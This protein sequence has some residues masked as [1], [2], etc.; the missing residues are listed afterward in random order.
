MNVTVI[1]N[2]RPKEVAK[3]DMTYEE[4][5]DLAFPGTPGNENI[6]YT[7]TYSKGHGNKP[8][9]NMVAGDSVKVKDG[10]VFNVSRTD[11][12]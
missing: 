11:K 3:D 7:V 4:I 2:G 10:M 9:A 8:E 6:I 12:S 1:V 5:V